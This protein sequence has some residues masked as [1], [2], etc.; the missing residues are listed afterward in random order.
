MKKCNNNSIIPISEAL[1]DASSSLMQVQQPQQPKPQNRILIAC[2]HDFKL[3]AIMESKWLVTLFG[4]EMSNCTNIPIDHT[5][6]DSTPTFLYFHMHKE[7]YDKVFERYE[8][9]GH[10]FNVIHISDE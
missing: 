8:K 3:D 9:M 2:D 4:A 7:G 6:L 10:S 5:P 1:R